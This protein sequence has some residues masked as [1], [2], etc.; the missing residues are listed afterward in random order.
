MMGKEL[1]WSTLC[2][3]ICDLYNE[4]VEKILFSTIIVFPG[5][6]FTGYQEAPEQ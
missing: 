4:E 3:V 1:K 5:K 2:S 6:N